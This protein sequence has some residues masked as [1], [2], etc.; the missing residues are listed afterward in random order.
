MT[1]SLLQLAKD[2]SSEKKHELAKHVTGLLTARS[3]D[4]SSEETHLL[5]NMLE[6]VYESLELEARKHMS[7]R[8]ADVGSTS[9]KLAEAM[10]NDELSVAE[11]ILERS[12]S[13]SEDALRSIAQKKDQGH[14]LAMAKRDHISEDVTKLLVK[15][16]GKDVRHALASNLGA[17]MQ[18]PVFED[19]VKDMPK[20]MGDRIRHL[21]KSNEELI[22]DLFREDGE[23]ASGQ[24]LEKRPSK[25]SP[26]RSG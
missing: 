20:Q 23:I 14:L 25:I 26:T 12:K 10:A 18:M 15:R 5:N 3:E 2:S 8:L 9:A 4:G 22:E 16:G 21:R 19:L 7:Q 11:A 1:N 13:I 17:E 6:G 24:K